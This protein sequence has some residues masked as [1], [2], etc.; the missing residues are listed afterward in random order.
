MLRVEDPSNGQSTHNVILSKQQKLQLAEYFNLIVCVEMTSISILNKCLRH[1]TSLLF[2][3]YLLWQ[4]PCSEAPVL[5]KACTD[6]LL[7]V[8][9]A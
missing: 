1:L 4:L 3:I 2:H 7:T 5:N 6:L 8:V 9:S